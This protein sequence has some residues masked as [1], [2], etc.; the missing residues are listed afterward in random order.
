MLGLISSRK[1]RGLIVAKPKLFET[2][3]KIA[4][5]QFFTKK[6][7]EDL[8]N[9]RIAIEV[10][11]ADIL[12][13]NLTENDIRK[14]QEIVEL[15]M[16]RPDDLSL[17]LECDYKFHLQIYKATGSESILSFQSILYDFFNDYEERKNYALP[18]YGKRFEDPKRITHLDILNAIKTKNPRKIS[19]AMRKH[20]SIH[21]LRE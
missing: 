14:M 7:Q 4:D 15:E 20:L 18:D 13:L 21:L 5:P 10:G 11:L 9:L 12:V 19:E 1:K 16:S 3:K 17:Y 8:Y 2:V 6:E